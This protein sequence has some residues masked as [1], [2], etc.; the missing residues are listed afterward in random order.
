MSVSSKM[1]LACGKAHE[2]PAHSLRGGKETCRH[3][4]STTLQ[5]KKREDKPARQPD[6][7]AGQGRMGN[8]DFSETIRS[9]T[10]LTSELI[11]TVFSG[12][13]LLIMVCHALLDQLV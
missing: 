4:S 7:L 10:L 5:G 6:N 1:C 2:G 11:V 8:T 13:G 9:T 3:N 12:M